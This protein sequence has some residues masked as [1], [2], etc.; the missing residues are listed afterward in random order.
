MVVISYLNAGAVVLR[1]TRPAMLRRRA[2]FRRSANG[3]TQ[4][5]RKTRCCTVSPYRRRLL[6]E[7]IFGFSSGE[8]LVL[9]L[10]FAEMTEDESVGLARS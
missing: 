3:I 8:L 5:G 6:L 7:L 10:R 9:V 1:E 4:S 2:R